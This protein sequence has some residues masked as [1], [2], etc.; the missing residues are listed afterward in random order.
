MYGR[1]WM[2]G[3]PTRIVM[4]VGAATFVVGALTQFL[5]PAAAALGIVWY[6]IQIWESKTGR[7][8]RTWICRGAIRMKRIFFTL[9]AALLLVP[10]AFA[11]DTL[12]ASQAECQ[13]FGWDFCSTLVNGN[14]DPGAGEVGTFVS[15]DDGAE[16]LVSCN[17][18]HPNVP[19]ATQVVINWIKRQHRH[20]FRHR[21]GCTPN[22]PVLNAVIEA[23]GTDVYRPFLEMPFADS[24][25]NYY[26]WRATPT[27]Q[28][29]VYHWMS[30]VYGQPY[31]STNFVAGAQ[32]FSKKTAETMAFVAGSANGQQLD[33][34]NNWQMWGVTYQGKCYLQSQNQYGV[35]LLKLKFSHLY[36]KWAPADGTGWG[37]YNF[38]TAAEFNC[39]NGEANF[40][41]GLALAA[42]NYVDRPGIAYG[43]VQWP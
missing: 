42:K 23:T 36:G 39:A 33:N 34:P 38:A 31:W 25:Q 9:F 21:A 43:A 14:I 20:V 10:V 17:A 18:R 2:E 16:S 19:Q 28:G 41:A 1:G 40:L 4:D 24:P 6:C 13:T 15:V 8:W 22:H 26:V 3:S 32:R 29:Y 35:S 11:E 5:P 30:I 27:L 12:T 37:E 7:Q